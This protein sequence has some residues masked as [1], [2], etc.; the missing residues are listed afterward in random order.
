ARAPQSAAR[1]WAAARTA[2]RDRPRRCRC[3]HRAP[4]ARL[5]HGG[6]ARGVRS[7]SVAVYRGLPFA[8]P[9]RGALRFAAPVPA[10]GWQGERDC[11]QPGP[12]APQVPRGVTGTVQGDADCLHLSVWAPLAATPDAALPVMVWVHGGGFMRGS[13]SEAL[14]DGAA[15]A[16]GGVVFVSLQY[17][18]GMD[19]F[20]HFPGVPAN[21]G[22]LDLQEGLRW[23]QRE[24]GHFG[25]DPQRVTLFG[26]SAGAGAVACLMSMP[27]ARGLFQQVALQSP[28]VTC[29]SL[30]DAALSREA[31]AGVLQ[32]P[33]TQ[34]ALAAQPLPEVL[35]AVQCLAADAALRQ[36]WGLGPRH[37]FPLRPVVDGDVLRQAPVAAMQQAW[38]GQGGGGLRGLLVGANAQ[39]MRLYHVPTGAIGR[40]ADA[41]VQAF[42]TQMGLPDRAV[43]TYARQL[44]TAHAGELLCQMQTDGYYRAPAR[45]IARAGAAS[46]Q[47]TYLYA[48]DWQSPQWRGQ[49]GA[50]H[51][52]D[53]P[54]VFQTLDTPAGR[55]LVGPAP[56]AALAP[57]MHGAWLRFARDGDPGWPAHTAQ[58]P[59]HMRFNAGSRSELAP[60][61]DAC[62]DLWDAAG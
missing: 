16:R 18:L 19:G 39:E 29:H 32:V 15:F 54:F 49:L 20:M 23:V 11:S 27:A 21:R 7:G 5:T 25:G 28:S 14:Y 58:E 51:G 53:L 48:F 47:P 31:I 50:A 61:S 55:E 8:L 17:R 38:A 56:P 4:R 46:R 26:Q 42:S 12:A 9:P 43:S 3:A 37:F 60:A 2:G 22:L 44:G 24:I 1:P 34:Q 6:V 59:W 35:R 33:A 10:P 57:A 40:F 52:V 45:Q 36:R 13:A 30:A 41:D 62:L